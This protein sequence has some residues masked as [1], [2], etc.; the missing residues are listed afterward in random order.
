MVFA[1]EN[2]VESLVFVKKLIVEHAFLQEN[3]WFDENFIAKLKETMSMALTEPGQSVYFWR[4]A[5]K[6]LSLL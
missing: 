6:P 4:Q 2:V 3:Q 1:M 5:I